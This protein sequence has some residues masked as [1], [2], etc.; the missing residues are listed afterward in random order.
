MKTCTRVYPEDWQAW[1]LHRVTVGGHEGRKDALWIDPRARTVQFIKRD[2][3][4]RMLPHRTKPYEIATRVRW[5]RIA[6]T[7]YRD[8]PIY[9]AEWWH[10]HGAHVTIA[11]HVRPDNYADHWK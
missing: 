4:G 5:G 3:A 2:S 9:M 6:V 11:D 8:T 10:K 1:C 7:L